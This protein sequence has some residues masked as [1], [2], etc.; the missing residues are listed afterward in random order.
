MIYNTF[1]ERQFYRSS[2]GLSCE[3]THQQGT[4]T[5]LCLHQGSHEAEKSRVHLLPR[6]RLAA[7]DELKGRG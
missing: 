3:K 7:I 5:R 6:D 2:T 4:A 1:I